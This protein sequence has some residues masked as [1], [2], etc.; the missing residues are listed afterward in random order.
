[1]LVQGQLS[2]LGHYVASEEIRQPVDGIN[3]VDEG[4]FVAANSISEANL[5][6]TPAMHPQKFHQQKKTIKTI[7]ALSYGATVY[8]P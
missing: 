2:H 1:M 4:S 8:I 6:G 7:A 5:F 3:N